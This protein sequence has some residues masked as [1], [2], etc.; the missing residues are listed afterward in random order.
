[1][2]LCFTNKQL[3]LSVC[4]SRFQPCRFFYNS[5]VTVVQKRRKKTNKWAYLLIHTIAGTGSHSNRNRYYPKPWQQREGKLMWAK[6]LVKSEFR[7]IIPETLNYYIWRTHFILKNWFKQEWENYG[8][9]ITCSPPEHNLW[10]KGKHL[11]YGLT[12][13]KYYFWLIIFCVIFLV[14]FLDISF[15][16]LFLPNQITNRLSLVAYKKLCRSVIS[17][18]L[19]RKYTILVIMSLILC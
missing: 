13:P 19:N 8:L 18:P 3:I 14:L 10:P 16:T 17:F 15:I 11:L 1:M 12:L 2:I 5:S 7:P 4:F 6:W 9:S